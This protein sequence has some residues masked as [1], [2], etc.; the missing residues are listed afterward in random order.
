M[1]AEYKSGKK[2]SEERL[3]SAHRLVLTGGSFMLDSV[4]SELLD[5][6]HGAWH[7]G[8]TAARSREL[9]APTMDHGPGDG[10]D[11]PAAV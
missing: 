6:C 2:K 4:L 10:S 7:R 3:L 5:G 8:S 9:T 11:T 1:R